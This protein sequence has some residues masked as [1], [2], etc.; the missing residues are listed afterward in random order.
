MVSREKT[1]IGG[2]ILLG[3]RVKKK[4]LHVEILQILYCTTT[5][6]KP[7]GKRGTKTLAHCFL[8]PLYNMVARAVG[9]ST[10][11]ISGT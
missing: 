3:G 1:N 5:S 8:L 6:R 11:D 2:I 10:R 4:N 7:E 9:M